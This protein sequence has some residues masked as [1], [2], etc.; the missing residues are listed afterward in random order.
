MKVIRHLIPNDAGWHLSLTQ[1]FDPQK[2]RKEK[3]PI[4]IVPGYGMNS[5][6]FS[7]HPNGVSLEGHLLEQGYEVWRA[8]LREQG[9]SVKIGRS[10]DYGL[11]DLAMVDLTAILNATVERTKST[12]EKVDVIGASLGGSLMF[13]HA[14]LNPAHHIGAM[15][16]MGS[17][18]RWIRV[19]PL[20]RVAFVS[21]MLAGLVRVRGTRRFA[22]AVMPL[23]VKHSPWLL[24]IYMNPDLTD[25][26]AIAEMVHTV[27]DPNRHINKEL[28]RWIKRRDLV[29]G[30][31]NI[32]EKLRTIKNPFLCVLAHG[33]GVVPRETAAFSFH[34]IG[35]K[36]KELLIIGDELMR[37]AHADL[38]VSTQAAERI[39]RPI[40]TWLARCSHHAA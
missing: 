39:F 8:D 9:G 3:P 36:D 40:S 30:G 32:A 16:A 18:V 14:V 28:A 10:P 37:H 12:H 34:Q 20:V 11:E 4:L 29:I 1:T 15:I 2:V 31:V 22:E 26:T 7:Y 13:A 38:F 35:S 27:E 17:P 25:T 23:L 5:F 21:P 19:H 24:S 33:D 6:I